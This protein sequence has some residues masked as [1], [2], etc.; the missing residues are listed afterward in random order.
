MIDKSKRNIEYDEPIKL[1]GKV[2]STTHSEDVIPE[3]STKKL[4][5]G[6]MSTEIASYTRTQFKK[7]FAKLM[8]KTSI[9]GLKNILKLIFLLVSS[10]LLY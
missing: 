3:L 6:N 1:E 8:E 9:S 2:L 7:E 10:H 4:L 5:L